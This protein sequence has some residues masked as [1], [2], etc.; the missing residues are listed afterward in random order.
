M[1]GA[2][3]RRVGD[4][5]RQ[6]H[7]AGHRAEID[8]RAPLPA[9]HEIFAEDLAAEENTLHVHA[10][11]AVE[12]LLG[13]VEE[14]RG[15]IDA[16]AIDDNVDPAAA[17]EHGGE[18]ALDLGLAGGLGGVKPGLAAGGGDLVEPRLRL[19]GVAADNDDL[20]ARAGQAFSHGT[21]QFAGAADDDCDLAGEV[22]KLIQVF[23]L[24]HFVGKQGQ[25][26]LGRTGNCSIE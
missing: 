24:I 5:A 21:A 20:G 14:G 4:D 13:D 16:G 7:D 25:R 9:V 8:D 2:L 10:Q 11:D 26:E 6:R 17:L 22:K 1:H 12:L 23:R 18:Q 15:G 19:L 3:R